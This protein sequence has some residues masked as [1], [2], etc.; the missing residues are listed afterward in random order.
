MPF[1]KLWENTSQLVN[2]EL[3]ERFPLSKSLSVALNIRKTHFWVEEDFLTWSGGGV[4]QKKSFRAE[5]TF[6]CPQSTY[7][8][9]SQWGSW[10]SAAGVQFVCYYHPP[11]LSLNEM[12]K[13]A[14]SSS[15]L[16]LTLRQYKLINSSWGPV[17]A[18]IHPLSWIYRNQY[19]F[20]QHASPLCN[21]L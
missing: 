8:T 14:N 20:T 6:L 17:V 18:A 19:L 3:P 9:T 2:S 5:K 16:T 12:E 10:I 15:I 11:P 13:T 21:D 7:C 4:L 1:L